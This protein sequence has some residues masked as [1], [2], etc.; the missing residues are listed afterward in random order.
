MSEE[1]QFVPLADCIHSHFSIRESAIHFSV[2]VKYN[3]SAHLENVYQLVRVDEC[4]IGL[5]RGE[6]EAHSQVFS[7]CSAHLPALI[8]LIPLPHLLLNEGHLSVM[9]F[10]GRLQL[11]DDP[12][13]NEGE[14]LVGEAEWKKEGHHEDLN[15]VS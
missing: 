11:E 5:V 10:R 8:A 4:R 3:V 2:S 7:P 15:E 13:A 1:P 12:I 9:C 14:L 6:P